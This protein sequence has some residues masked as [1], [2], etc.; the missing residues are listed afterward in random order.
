LARTAATASA[1]TITTPGAA[2]V[3]T[4]LVV[5]TFGFPGGSTGCAG[6]AHALASG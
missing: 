3:A 5:V 2:E 4:G 1:I 6:A